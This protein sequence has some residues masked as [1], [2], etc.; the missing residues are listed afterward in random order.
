MDNLAPNIAIILMNLP[1][2]ND[3]Q[4]AKL[5]DVVSDIALVA[6]ASVALPAVLERLHIFL[7]IA[8]VIAALLLWI[9]SLWL[10]KSKN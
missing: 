5:A 6:L 10:L 3:N 9:M 4:I 7:A 2:L 8:G 1:E